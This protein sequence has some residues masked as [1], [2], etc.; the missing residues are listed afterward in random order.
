MRT[1]KTCTSFTS[2]VGAIR[3]SFALQLW[4]QCPATNEIGGA[5]G[6]HEHG[7]IGIATRYPWHDG[8]VC[9]AQ[10]IDTQYAQLGIHDA[11]GAG[12]HRTGADRV[13]R[14]AGRRADVRVQVR[15]ALRRCAGTTSL[16]MRSA[17]GE[18]A[19]MARGA[20]SPAQSHKILGF[21]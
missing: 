8:R 20:Q 6:N 16:S 1:S 13:L 10:T 4:R 19:V 7:A 18:V 11:A 17:C 12:R 2:K 3:L 21:R 5:F 14:H 9:D 15:V